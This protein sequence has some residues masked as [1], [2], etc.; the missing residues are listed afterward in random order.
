[1]KNKVLAML[2]L[3]FAVG[4]LGLSSFLVADEFDDLF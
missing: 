1:M 2:I 4:T 3:S